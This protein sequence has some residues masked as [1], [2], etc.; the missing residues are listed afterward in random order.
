MPRNLTSD[1]VSQLREAIREHDEAHVRLNELVASLGKDL[2][3]QQNKPRWADQQPVVP[4]WP[5]V[6]ERVDPAQY[7]VDP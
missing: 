2:E 1:E 4:Q 6:P 3:L 7:E 5:T